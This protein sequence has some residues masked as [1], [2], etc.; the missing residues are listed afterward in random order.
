MRA[1]FRDKMKNEAVTSRD[2]ILT[3]GHPYTY[4]IKNNPLNNNPVNVCDD[5]I[6][7]EEK[8]CLAKLRL[9]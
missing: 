2:P 9:F 7:N 3:Q 5:T 8:K 4:K 1:Y 6:R